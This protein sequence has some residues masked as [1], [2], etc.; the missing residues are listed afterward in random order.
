[1]LFHVRGNMGG[2][3]IAT[4]GKVEKLNFK[5]DSVL[6]AAVYPS[7][8]PTKNYVVFS[9][10][11]TGQAF[12]LIDTEKIEVLDYGSDLLF[13]NVDTHE[14]S[15]IERTD[16]A[17]ETFPSW[18]PDGKKIY[19]C[20]A[21]V[22]DLVG[23]PDS[24]KINYVLTNY[25]QLHYNIKSV[26]FDEQTMSFGEPQVEVD[27]ASMDKSATVPRVSPDGRYLL[28]TLGDFGQFH[29]WHKSS[30]QWVKN[31]QTGEMYPLAEA[32]SADVDTYHS[33]SSN[34]RWFVFSSRRDDGSYTRPYI[35]Y[36]DKE[37]KTRKAFMLPQE[38]PTHNLMLMK[39]YNVPELTREP[40]AYDYDMF[41][42][43]I[44][45]Q[46][47]GTEI[48][49]RELRTT[50]AIARQNATFNTADSTSGGQSRV[51]GMSGA[52][53]RADGVS[54]ATKQADGVSGAT[55]QAR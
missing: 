20:Q 29:I 54:G 43:A 41:H 10:N 28:F 40:A 17:M 44:Y 55:Q 1:M 25:R 48:K 33:W 35:A 8:H 50:E 45:N 27:C 39:S 5:N 53:Q 23:L 30:D 22:P 15:N 3:L 9:S 24:A 18:A 4:D 36:F 47:P 21:D 16:N 31:L 32:N 6:G 51:D 11:R 34:G 14:V 13:Y 26:T 46:I 42:D 7:W 52:T 49:Y 19:Y 2:T 37:G 38:D 12:H